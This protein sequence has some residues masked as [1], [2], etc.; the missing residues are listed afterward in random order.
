MLLLVLVLVLNPALRRGCH[1]MVPLLSP[2]EIGWRG[3]S[4]SIRNLCRCV[5]Q[6]SAAAAHV[7]RIYKSIHYLFI[8]PFL[9][10]VELRLE[11]PYHQFH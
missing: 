2:H 5:V 11:V 6:W 1:S 9:G 4:P 7:L 10:D 8:Y 3:A